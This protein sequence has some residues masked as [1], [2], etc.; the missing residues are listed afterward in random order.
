MD[1]RAV[2]RPSNGGLLSF[3]IQVPR[4]AFVLAAGHGTRLRPLT[5]KTPK[6]LLPVRG[7]PMLRIW[8]ERCQHYGVEEILINLHSNAETVREFLIGESFPRV[9]VH[10]SDEPMLL[11]SAGTIHTNRDWVAGERS[12]WV[13][14]ADVLTNVDLSDM[15]EY[16]ERLGAMATLGVYRAPDPSSCGI[17]QVDTRGWITRF[18][19]KPKTP[20]GDL[21]FSGV[22]LARDEFLRVL[23]DRRPA[24]IGFDV[25]PQ[26][27][28]RMAA[29]EIKEYLIDIGTMEN[30]RSAQVNWPGLQ[31]HDQQ[32][33]NA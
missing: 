10:V 31:L 29:Y 6:C 9:R 15:V 7:V 20:V 32:E 28:S 16:H 3:M 22:L 4:K 17:V 27:A 18:V 12:F 21:A 2:E 13:F 30:Y 26:L 23:P 33:R 25:L 1:F 19:E 11:G 5:D 8:L 14:Y 24:D